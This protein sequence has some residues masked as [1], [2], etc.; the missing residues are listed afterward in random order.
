M[1]GPD[2]NEELVVIFESANPVAL[3]I[4]KSA[5]EDAGIEFV[6]P[7]EGRIGF[8]VTP[9]LNPVYR[10]EVLKSY[11]AAARALLTD[12]TGKGDSEPAE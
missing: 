3:D 11:E 6:V 7:D 1:A 12:M 9:I 8:G 10:I 4:A 2:P 5:L